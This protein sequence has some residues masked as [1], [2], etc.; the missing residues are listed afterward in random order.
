MQISDLT[1]IVEGQLQNT[2]AISF[3]TQI[4]TNITA[5]EIKDIT[6]VNE[7]KSS[8]PYIKINISNKL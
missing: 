7:G 1:D 2:P 6:N 3:I 4:H 8:F 5:L